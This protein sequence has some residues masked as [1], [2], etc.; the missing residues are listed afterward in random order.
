MCGNGF[1]VQLWPKQKQDLFQGLPYPS[2]PHLRRW[3][4]G[5]VNSKG[6]HKILPQLRSHLHLTTILMDLEPPCGKS[7]CLARHICVSIPCAAFGPPRGSR[8]K[9]VLGPEQELISAGQL[10]VEVVINKDKNLSMGTSRIV[11]IVQFCG[12]CPATASKMGMLQV[13]A[14]LPAS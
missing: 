9:P 13:G 10:A 4:G 3:L 14:M 7:I 11:E 12:K 6:G 8:L 1:F 2:L 5:V